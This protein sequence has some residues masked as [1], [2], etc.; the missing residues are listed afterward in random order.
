MAFWSGCMPMYIGGTDFS[1]PNNDNMPLFTFGSTPGST[2]LY[3]ETT[4]YIGGAEFNPSGYMNMFIEGDSVFTDTRTMNLF[5][6]GLGNES[7]YQAITDEMTL[8]IKNAWVVDSGNLTLV[9]WNQ[10]AGAS[11]SVPISGT[12][13]LFINRQFESLHHNLPL[14]ITGPSGHNDNMTLFMQG[15]PNHRSGTPLYMHG[16]GKTTDGFTLYS[17]GF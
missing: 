17:H 12:M 3:E 4:L 10:Q 16:V 14:F 13:N 11:G 15:L 1:T 7:G 6:K 8:F 5:M 2:G 9:A